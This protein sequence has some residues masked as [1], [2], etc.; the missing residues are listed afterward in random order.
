MV[1]I[2]SAV[3][4]AML[5]PLASANIAC[6]GPVGYLGMDQA[7]QVIVAVGANINTICSTTSQ[8]IYQVDP[9]ACRSWYATLV[10]YRL[11][12]RTLTIWYND[13]ALTSCAQIGSWSTQRSAY[14][15]EQSY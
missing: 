14:F 7:G 9:V 4:L 5:S 6:T 3:C 15:I 12:D 2:L 10:A 8:S 1:R 11:S 13:P